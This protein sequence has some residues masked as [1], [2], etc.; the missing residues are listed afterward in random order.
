MLESST[1]RQRLDHRHIAPKL[2]AAIGGV[3][4][5]L[6][7]RVLRNEDLE[8]LVDTTNEWIVERTGILERRIA[9][10]DET[11]STM[12]AKAAIAACDSAGIDPVDVEMVIVATVTPDHLF[13]STACLVQAQIGAKKAACFDVNAACTGFMYATSTATA[14]ISSGMYRNVLVIGAETLSRFVNYHDRAT[15]ILFGDGAGAVFMQ[16]S[17]GGQGVAYCSLGADGVRADLLQIPGGGSK[18][19]PSTAMIEAG[20][21]YMQLEGGRVFR[22]ATEMLIKVIREAMETCGLSREDV[23]LV[24]PH[25][26][27]RRIIDA[28]MRKLGMS[29]DR[30]AI[31]ID[32]YGNTS[33]ASIP[34]AMAEA[35][36][37]GRLAPGTNVILAGVGA[38]LTW[39]ATVIKM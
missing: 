36:E 10:A 9:A 31:N 19:P 20:L 4:T 22:F 6:P 27:N 11:T 26:V 30:W 7:E 16:P 37:Q 38:G 2:R 18:I 21:Q 28:A 24:V 12:A 15:C 34:I 25:Q 29:E 32:R 8:S 23:G 1:R 14:F 33:A 3:G 35:F 5:Y 17:T 13:P 39:G